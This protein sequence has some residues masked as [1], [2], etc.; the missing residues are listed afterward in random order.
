MQAAASLWRK[1]RSATRHS[2]NEEEA[3]MLPKRDPD[4]VMMS[5]TT[6]R[7]M[8]A[9]HSLETAFAKA[10]PILHREVEPAQTAQPWEMPAD[11]KARVF[12][13]ADPE[14]RIRT[15]VEFKLSKKMCPNHQD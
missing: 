14:Q 6:H 1:I 9:E 10:K 13:I 7:R 5:E 4:L 15:I 11:L 12:A 2:A 3:H 8:D